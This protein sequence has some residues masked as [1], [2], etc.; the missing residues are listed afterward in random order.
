MDLINLV[1]SMTQL[2]SVEITEIENKSLIIP[3]STTLK[4]C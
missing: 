4:K 3:Q 2:S 1:K